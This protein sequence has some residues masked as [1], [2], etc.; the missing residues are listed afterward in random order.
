MDITVNYSDMKF[1]SE[2]LEKLIVTVLEKGAELQDVADDA[3][4]S[5]LICA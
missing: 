3:E 4:I 1:Y 2:A 5:V